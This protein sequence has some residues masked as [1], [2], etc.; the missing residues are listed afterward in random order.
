MPTTKDIVVKSLENSHVKSLLGNT[1]S[2]LRHNAAQHLVVLGV[3]PI[4]VILLILGGEAPIRPVPLSRRWSW[5][6]RNNRYGSRHRHREW[7]W[8]WEQAAEQ[9]SGSASSYIS[10]DLTADQGTKPEAW[11]A[12][13]S[14][15][16]A[17]SV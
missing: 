17:T 12:T 8:E 2:V 3:I 1:R 14:M 7:E 9:A 10:K 15:G 6:S 5:R 13:E 11:P 4:R 16:R